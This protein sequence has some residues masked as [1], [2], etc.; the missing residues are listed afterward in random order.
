MFGKDQPVILQLHD[1]TDAQPLFD[2]IVMELYDC[3]FPLLTEIITTDHPEVAFNNVDIALLVGARPRGENMERKDLLLKNAEIFTVQGKALNAVASRNVKVLVVGNP[4]NTN[5][6][7]AAS[8]APG[9]ERRNFTAMMRL[10]HNRSLGQLARRRGW[11]SSRALAKALVAPRARFV[12]RRKLR[13]L[14]R[15]T[16]TTLTQPH[17]AR[18]VFFHVFHTPAIPRAAD[19]LL[20]MTPGQFRELRDSGMSP[21][22]MAAISGRS[23]DELAG[24]LDALLV[25]RARRAMAT[26][27]S[28]PEQA[29]RL[30]QLQR[31]AMQ[32]FLAHT[33]RTPEEQ[34][35]FACSVHVF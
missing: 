9:I 25:T 6:L 30:L 33:Y 23:A 18:H 16:L 20:D 13:T 2:G 7:I 8:N 12:S 34:F 14:R 32:T 31:D 21:L 26:R 10:D 1:I 5:S 15:R 27:S 4:A 22:R 3:A 29:G 19:S 35:Q 24:S 28:T 11:R 17:L